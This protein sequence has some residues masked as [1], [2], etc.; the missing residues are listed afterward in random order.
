MDEPRTN[1]R[2]WT[3]RDAL[4]RGAVVGGAAVWTVPTVQTIG[5]RVALGQDTN[6]TPPPTDP[7]TGTGTVSGTV[8]DARTGGPISGATVT[9]AGQSMVTGADGAFLLTNVTAGTQ[10]LTGSAT[11]YTTATESIVVPDGG[12]VVENLALSPSGVITAVLTWGID[13]RDLDIHASG[14]DGSGGRFHCYFAD[15]NPVPHASLDV[16]D[17]SSEGPE[18][19]TINLGGGSS[20]FVA[21]QYEFWVHHFAGTGDFTTS[22]ARVVLTGQT[23]QVGEWFAADA[24]GTVDR[25]WRVVGFDLDAA[26]VI[27]NVTV[28]QVFAAGDSSTVFP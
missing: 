15:Q 26:G 21:G 12:S 28:R 1:A 16:D 3:R 11:G 24:S 10:T 6:G 18:T 23:A 17:V 2:T 7:G 22:G 8:L 9:V 14:P 19:I 4:R 25:I 5:Q 20:S 13:P 27:S